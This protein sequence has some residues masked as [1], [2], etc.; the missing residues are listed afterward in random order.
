MP[1]AY[2]V[3][4]RPCD[5]VWLSS[6]QVVGWG[7]NPA[8]AMEANA[9]GNQQ[10]LQEEVEILRCENQRL[11]RHLQR[12]SARL[13]TARRLA[14]HL[15][16]AYLHLQ[17]D[18]LNLAH[19]RPVLVEPSPD[20]ADIQL[21]NQEARDLLGDESPISTI[22]EEEPAIAVGDVP[23]PSSTPRAR[24]R[25]PPGDAVGALAS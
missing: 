4:C 18:L 6:N 7:C 9:G 20:P 11:R 5:V 14:Y 8:A 22:S 13:R 17:A 21:V 2:V 16:M 19:R 1:E 10:L 12:V 25:T 23:R 3:R 24:S 15:R